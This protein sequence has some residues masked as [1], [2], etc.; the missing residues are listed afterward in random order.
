MFS[1]VLL[2]FI[3][4]GEVDIILLAYGELRIILLEHVQVVPVFHAA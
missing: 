2:D 4:T 1:R 3:N